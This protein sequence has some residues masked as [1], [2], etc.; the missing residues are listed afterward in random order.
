[1]SEKTYSIKEGEYNPSVKS[2]TSGLSR[3]IS[4]YSE[5]NETMINRVEVIGKTLDDILNQL[6][7]ITGEI[8][9]EEV[10]IS[11]DGTTYPPDSPKG[12]IGEVEDRI[13]RG[14]SEMLSRLTYLSSQVN[15]IA[16]LINRI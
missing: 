9:G 3:I 11:K 8:D 5:A 16:K 13:R 14:Q 12:V 1:M 2:E 4:I 15:S 10:A 6:A 7:T